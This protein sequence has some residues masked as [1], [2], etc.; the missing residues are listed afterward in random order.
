LINTFLSFQQ[1]SKAIEDA[2]GWTDQVYVSWV[3]GARRYVE[4]RVNFGQIFEQ[5]NKV[6]S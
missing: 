6:F 5:Y 1:Y 4:Q 2:A 3:K